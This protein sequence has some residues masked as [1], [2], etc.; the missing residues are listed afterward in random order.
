MSSIDVLAA[1]SEVLRPD[2]LSALIFPA[3]EHWIPPTVDA[4]LARLHCGDWRY[5]VLTPRRM[6]RFELLQA[7]QPD[8]TFQ[9]TLREVWQAWRTVD[10]LPSSMPSSGSLS[11]ARGRLPVWAL[12]ALFKHTAMLTNN[13]QPPSAWAGHRLL[14][15]DG[16]LTPVPN[17]PGNR[18]YFGT[19]RSQHGE[20]YYPQVLAVWI[21][22]LSNGAVLAERAEPCSVGEETI[23]PRLVPQALH[24]G[25]VLLGDGR[26]GTYALLSQVFRASAF[27]LTRAPGPLD[28]CRHVTRRWTA[29]DTDICLKRT[30]YVSGRHADLRLPEQLE[31]RAV[32][33]DIP[34][35]DILNGIEHADFLT[36]LPRDLFST[37]VL[38]R[39]ARLRWG[40][41]T[42]NNDI[43]TRLGLG[44]IRSQ[45]PAG[46]RREIL[47][48][49]CISNLMHLELCL[50]RPLIPLAGSF[51]AA[52][53]ALYQANQQLRSPACLHEKVRAVL[54]EMILQQPLDVR[55]DRTEPRM[56][57]PRKR[58][59]RVFKTARA[60]WRN[61][62]KAG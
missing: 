62:R 53:S 39:M 8:M 1:A 57:R 23:A 33:F 19:T 37:A 42:V 26:I 49:L 45:N 60:Q 46:V 36:N 38:A 31:L 7:C 15:L 43:K 35:R 50:A 13:A 20:A 40:H 6:L 59:H 47:A 2:P 16:C 44:E 3:I 10:P 11:E 41:E 48:H 18:A 29:D 12:E 4:A 21:S 5:D 14:A 61:E 17:S 24:P 56:I 32:S 34:S 52:R 22:L 55:N 9:E 27:F 25:D 58:T 28:V 30:A 51:T 54:Q